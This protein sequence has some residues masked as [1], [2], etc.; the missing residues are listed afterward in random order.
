MIELFF[1]KI[2]SFLILYNLKY[3]QGLNSDNKIITNYSLATFYILL[4]LKKENI[5]YNLVYDDKNKKLTFRFTVDRYN[6]IILK[7]I[8]YYNHSQ[9]AAIIFNKKYTKIKNSF[10]HKDIVISS[11]NT[12]IGPILSFY[13]AMKLNTGGKL[14]FSFNYSK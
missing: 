6:K 10:K 3:R 7:N 5:I 8:K 12:S 1:N 13:Q 2:N 14:L 4:F 11:S 9:R